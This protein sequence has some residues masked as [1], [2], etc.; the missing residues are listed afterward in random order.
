[1]HG[2]LSVSAKNWI[3]TAL[4]KCDDDTSVVLRLYDIEGK[5]A[6]GTVRFPVP[7][8]R[9]STASIIED[10]GTEVPHRGSEVP[11]RI[12]HHAIETFKVVPEH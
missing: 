11:M 2:F 1:V 3:V 6:E 5:D 10:D 7:L 9:A 12:G 8:A 4:K